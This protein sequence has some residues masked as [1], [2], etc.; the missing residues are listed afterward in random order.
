MIFL[1]HEADVLNNGAHLSSTA[2]VGPP[3]QNL[4]EP[5][6]THVPPHAGNDLQPV[7]K[8]PQLNILNQSSTE[9]RIVSS[10]C[11]SV[12]NLSGT[13]ND[14]IMAV[15]GGRDETF[16]EDNVLEKSKDFTSSS[17]QPDENSASNTTLNC[18]KL[19]A[20][21]KEAET[22]ASNSEAM[23]D[24]APEEAKLEADDSNTEKE[25]IDGGG[26][27]KMDDSV[28]PDGGKTED[29]SAVV[30]DAEIAQKSKSTNKRKADERNDRES[31]RHRDR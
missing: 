11:Q 18:S 23:D 5:D 30:H 21:N 16:T 25:E 2:E 7:A 12:A 8:K 3:V 14:S 9:V 6:V 27:E 24:K 20:K 4:T 31:K 10:E 1:F 26:T 28:A 17:I 13:P 19:E 29:V 15:Y 22:I